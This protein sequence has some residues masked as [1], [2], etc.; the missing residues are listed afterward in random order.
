MSDQ[1]PL[2]SK[3][4]RECL[5]HTYKVKICSVSKKLRLPSKLK[6]QSIYLFEQLYQKLGIFDYDMSL[7]LVAVVFVA[8]K[9]V[10]K[11][12]EVKEF[13]EIF[14]KSYEQVL[15][16]EKVILETFEFRLQPLLLEEAVLELTDELP[17]KK[18]DEVLTKSLLFGFCGFLDDQQLAVFVVYKLQNENQ[19]VQTMNSVLDSTETTNLVRQFSEL[20]TIYAK[21][22]CLLET[23]QNEERLKELAAKIKKRTKPLCM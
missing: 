17:E 1:E 16:L 11:Y 5:L 22:E 8:S 10:E 13:C 14:G 18:V 12:L 6:Y 20:D 2:I 15:F 19:F 7:V 4:D 21:K 3:E 23:E 9:V